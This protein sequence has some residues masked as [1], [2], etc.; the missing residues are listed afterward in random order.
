MTG[1]GTKPHRSSEKTK[2]KKFQLCEEVLGHSMATAKEHFP[3][4]NKT[5]EWCW[6]MGRTQNNNWHL[7]W[8]KYHPNQI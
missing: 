3:G 4:T 8:Q 6:R 5:R 7:V 1:I 2:R